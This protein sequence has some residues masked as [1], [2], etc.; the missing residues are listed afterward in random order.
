MYVQT[1]KFQT[2]MVAFPYTYCTQT[3]II[4]NETQRDDPVEMLLRK[5][6]VIELINTRTSGYGVYHGLLCMFRV[7]NSLFRTLPET[8]THVKQRKCIIDFLKNFRSHSRD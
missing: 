6:V 5:H 7:C 2:H 1:S 3:Y 8:L 4:E